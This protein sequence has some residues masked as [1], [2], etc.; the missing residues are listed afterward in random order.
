MRK[1]IK[2]PELRFS[3]FILLACLLSCGHGETENPDDQLAIRAR[4]D[5]RSSWEAGQ[6]SLMAGS[7]RLDAFSTMAISGLTADA[8]RLIGYVLY[9]DDFEPDFRLLG[10]L[11]SMYQLSGNEII[12][13]KAKMMG[14]SLLP[15]LKEAEP[16]SCILEMGMLSYFSGNPEFYQAAKERCKVFFSS[17]ESRGL[18]DET[19]EYNYESLYKGW[20]LFGD[21]DLLEMWKGGSGFFSGFSPSLLAL[22][23]QL[24]DAK[25][26]QYIQDSIFMQARGSG[27]GT[28]SIHQLIKSAWYMWELSGEMEYLD[29]LKGY[30]AELRLKFSD[31]PLPTD[32]LPESLKYFYLAFAG[33]DMYTLST[34]VFNSAGH[35]FLR[36]AL[37]PDRVRENLG[38]SLSTKA[39]VPGADSLDYLFESGTEGYA[40]FRIPAMVSTTN[41]TLLAFAE[42][43]KNGC[44]DTGDIDLVLKRSEDQGQSWSK[45]VVL[46]DDGNNVCGNPAPVVDEETGEIF[47]LSTW[48]HG[49]D[50][51]AEII[52]GT[53]RDSRRIF[54]MQSED[55]GISWSEAREI[56]ADVKKEDW[57][58]YATGPCHGIQ[59]QGKKNRGRL[60]IPCD[61]IEAGTKA[62]YSHVIYSDDH[63]KSWKLGGSTPQDQVNECTVAELPDGRLIL[64]M[65]NYDRTQK[66]RKISFSEDGGESWSKIKSDPEL[67]EPICQASMLMVAWQNKS[68]LYFLN[69]AH[70]DQR[71]NITL[72]SSGNGGESWQSARVL[73]PGP[74]A[75]SDLCLVSNGRLACLYEAGNKSPYQ[76][77]VFHML[78]P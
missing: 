9:A 63:G 14:R 36:A 13:E 68:T 35:P 1:L 66:S 25:D 61:H 41:G 75:Y 23:G 47:L 70:E 17:I 43:R 30:Y 21:G 4:F 50:R 53:S 71:Q 15:I 34:C 57:T 8:D 38:L 37:I 52:S 6:D 12:L 20:Q 26:S 16:G 69:P 73:Y 49:K 39:M 31:Q 18:E 45:L 28:S 11:L 27:S 40:C 56:S 33:Q 72:R 77:I 32:Y 51:E 10:G 55:D 3:P 67:I 74:S 59:L 29:M 48:N 64:N 76:G 19:I 42:G 5:S 54:V 78:S 46:W 58:W 65:R 2:R 24:S 60:L 7:G 62:Y 22:S 44:S